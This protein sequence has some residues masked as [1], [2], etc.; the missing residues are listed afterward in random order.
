MLVSP[1]LAVGGS[2]VPGGLAEIA[3]V[4]SGSE[5]GLMGAGFPFRPQVPLEF[6][7]LPIG[8]GVGTVPV[9]LPRPLVEIVPGA[10]SAIV[11]DGGSQLM[12][13]PGIVGSDASGTGARLVSA[14]PGRVA[15]ENGLGPFSGEEI[16]APGVVG[17]PI[18]VVP[19]VETCARAARQPSINSI[20]ANT[21]LDIAAP[22]LLTSP[23]SAA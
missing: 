17:N 21:S 18:A 5:A 22:L 7:A 3:G 2:N 6:S 14:A 19:M 4:I 10:D 16:T 23:A 13:A 11:A 20:S 15:A 12:T 9:A 1:R 8:A